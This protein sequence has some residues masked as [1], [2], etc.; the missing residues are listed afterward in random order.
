MGCGSGPRV[1]MAVGLGR[2]ALTGK[3]GSRVVLQ[4]LLGN[5]LQSSISW[6]LRFN[7]YLLS[8]NHT[9]ENVLDRSSHRGAVVNESD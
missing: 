2:C 8:V 6:D 1:G 9:T 4:W 5:F 3:Q 7:Q